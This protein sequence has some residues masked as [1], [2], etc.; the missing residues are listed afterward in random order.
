MI[1]KLEL[2]NE[3]REDVLDIAGMKSKCDG[4]GKEIGEVRAT[5]GCFGNNNTVFKYVVLC[6]DCHVV[7]SNAWGTV[8]EKGEN[9]DSSRR[10]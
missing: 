1:N 2:T 5:V 4:C 8:R 10:T 3:Q 9:D 6:I 7:M